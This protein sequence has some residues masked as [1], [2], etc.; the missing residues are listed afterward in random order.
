M[1]AVSEAGMDYRK[2]LRPTLAEKAAFSHALKSEPGHTSA[3]QS[4]H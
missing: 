3:D 2:H 4:G 1:I